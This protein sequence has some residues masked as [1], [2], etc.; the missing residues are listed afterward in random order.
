MLQASMQALKLLFPRKNSPG[1]PQ[2][3]T[4]RRTRKRD[5]P[6][7]VV[8]A[9]RESPRQVSAPSATSKGQHKGADVLSS[10]KA[11][12]TRQCALVDARRA[13]ASMR[14]LRRPKAHANIA[15]PPLV[16][17][18]MV[19]PRMQVR[20]RVFPQMHPQTGKSAVRTI[21]ARAVARAQVAVR[22]RAHLAPGRV[23]PVLAT[24]A[25]TEERAATAAATMAITATIKVALS[26]SSA[27]PIS[28]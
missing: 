10:A 27:H 18:A 2:R 23:T 3:A 21:G 6:S 24:L 12:T 25:Q 5:L 20:M 26:S 9:V 11:R 13:C 4:L 28:I 19:A 14:M 7:I 16:V 8:A 1:A 17:A 15:A 22:L